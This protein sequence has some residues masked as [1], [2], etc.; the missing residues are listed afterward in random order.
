MHGGGGSGQT[1]GPGHE[2]NFPSFSSR[3]LWLGSSTEG[4]MSQQAAEQGGSGWGWECG[5][6]PGPR[7][8]LGPFGSLNSGGY[9]GKSP[10][11]VRWRLLH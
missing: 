1:R 5:G 10:L 2:R 9:G 6:S 4:E 11:K 8:A 7:S 3:P